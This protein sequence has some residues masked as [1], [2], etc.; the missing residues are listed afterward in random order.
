[1][2]N[3]SEHLNKVHVYVLRVDIGG[4]HTSSALVG[5]ARWSVLRPELLFISYKKMLENIQVQE[6]DT[7]MKPWNAKA[8]T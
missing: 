1:M 3:M 4:T 8:G 2:C 6:S 7:T 5:V